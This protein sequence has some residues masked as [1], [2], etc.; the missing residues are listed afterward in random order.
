MISSSD[1]G[2][3]A[4][5]SDFQWKFHFFSIYKTNKRKRNEKP[6][7]NADPMNFLTVLAI[8]FQAICLTV[9]IVYFL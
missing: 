8:F 6:P 4:H 1:R 2:W 3:L 9:S 5:L 7:R